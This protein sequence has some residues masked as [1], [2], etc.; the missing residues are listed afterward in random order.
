MLIADGTLRRIRV[1]ISKAVGDI[2]FQVAQNPARNH[3]SL[4]RAQTE[5]NY[6][7][8]NFNDEYF[9]A[10][11]YTV[12]KSHKSCVHNNDILLVI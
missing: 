12:I 6:V 1:I 11:Y 3:V 8:W 4:V 5:W 9:I 7:S 2:L 10:G